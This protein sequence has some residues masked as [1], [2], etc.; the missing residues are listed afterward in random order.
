L[1]LEAFFFHNFF[2]AQQTLAPLLNISRLDLLLLTEWISSLMSFAWPQIQQVS[3][4][5][6][7][8]LPDQGSSLAKLLWL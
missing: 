6:L 8:S 7:S 3:D 5:E 4:T 1:K 2:L